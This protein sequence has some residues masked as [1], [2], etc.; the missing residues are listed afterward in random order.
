MNKAC[1]NAFEVLLGQEYDA[2]VA[3]DDL[4]G[5]WPPGCWMIVTHSP[6]RALPKSRSNVSQRNSDSGVPSLAV[7]LTATKV[8]SS[9]GS[10]TNNFS[11]S[12]L[13]TCAG[14]TT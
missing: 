10:V 5:F 9:S 4:L 3:Y 1:A 12:R 7:E 14:C 11:G 8:K 13:K 2:I 6:L